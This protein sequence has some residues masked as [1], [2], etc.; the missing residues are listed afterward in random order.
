MGGCPFA[1]GDSVVTFAVTTCPFLRSVARD[2]GETYAR[3]IAVAPARPAAG[4]PAPVLPESLDGVTATFELFHGQKGVVPLTGSR[5]E[6]LST[7]TLQA[8]ACPQQQSSPSAAGLHSTPR[9]LHQGP[10]PLAS[11]SSYSNRQA[12]FAAI[13]LS[14]L[15]F[16]PG[17]NDLFGRGRKLA[18]PPVIIGMRAAVARLPPVKSLRPQAFSVR[19]L[20]IGLVAALLNIPFGAAREHTAKFSPQWF[21]AVHATIPLIAPLRKAVLMPPQKA[22]AVRALWAQ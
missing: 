8:A 10:L 3:N 16:L 5:K 7:R 14:F 6:A 20:S 12:P 15:D 11:R 1:H 9:E 13:S 17:Y 21:L 2:Q 4:A 19:L 18:C 22:A